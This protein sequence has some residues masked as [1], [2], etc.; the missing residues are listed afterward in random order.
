MALFF[1]C[2]SQCV[3][4][5]LEAADIVIDGHVSPNYV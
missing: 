2:M 1:E 3:E 5:V 4:Q